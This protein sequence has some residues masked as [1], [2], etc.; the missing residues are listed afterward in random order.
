VSNVAT[1]AK[2][3]DKVG[4]TCEAQREVQKRSMRE[5]RIES[6]LSAREELKQQRILEA[7]EEMFRT[8]HP[9]QHEMKRSTRMDTV[10]LWAKASAHGQL[11]KHSGCCEL[12]LG[13]R[14]PYVIAASIFICSIEKAIDEKTPTLGIDRMHAIDLQSRMQR[15]STFSNPS[16][17]S[18]TGAAR[19]IIRLLES[20]ACPVC[21]PPPIE[22][23]IKPPP[24]ATKIN[25]TQKRLGLGSVAIQQAISK[26]FAAL[27][28]ELKLSVKLGALEATHSQTNVDSICALPGLRGQTSLATAFCVLHAVAKDPESA[29]GGLN[30]FCGPVLINFAL[31]RKL[32]LQNHEVEEVVTGIIKILQNFGA[33]T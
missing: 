4:R 21:K 23:K 31:G 12:R 18:Q 32:G 1:L 3:K 27:N 2:G 9:V 17:R 10:N 30:T 6:G 11:C 22:T 24:T 20:K 19:G 29:K 16:M 7:I 33:G 28:A 5:M 15:S 14:S 8:F 26:V 13:D 25:E